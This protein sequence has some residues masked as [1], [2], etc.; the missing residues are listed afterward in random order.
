MTRF[1]GRVA[2]VTGAASGIGRAVALRLASEGAAVTCLDLAVVGAEETA[3]EAR[4]AGGN[5]RA[6]GCDVSDAP[7]VASAFADADGSFG[8]PDVLCN[9]AGIGSFSH[10]EDSS[11]EEWDRIIAVNLRGTFLVCRQFIVRQG[12]LDAARARPA[13]SPRP[14]IVNI[15]S[16]AGLMGH[17]YGAAYSASKGGVVLLTRTLAVEFAERG[18]RVNA[19]APGG[20]D[21]PLI[22]S[23][24]LPEDASRRLVGRMIPPLGMAKP[25][26]IAAVVAFVAS[27]EASAMSGAVVA[28]DGSTVA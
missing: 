28:A 11:V 27:E 6:A 26:D 8:P 12:T 24:R 5:A 10:F 4:A 22:S 7:A 17:P 21:T 20:V 23:F 3:A 25:E 13:D 16:T 1:A 9:A 15:A 2:L 19:V 18:V 14:S